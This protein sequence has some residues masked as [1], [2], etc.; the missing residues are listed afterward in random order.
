[1]TDD[2]K[3]IV[4]YQCGALIVDCTS[5]HRE[6]C[7]VPELI[8]IALGSDE[9]PGTFTVPDVFGG[10]YYRRGAQGLQPAEPGVPDVVICR[11]LDAFPGH[12]A[13]A[14]GWVAPCAWCQ[15]PIVYNPRG[16]HPDKPRIC[17]PC[18]RVTPLPLDS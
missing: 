7:P 17:M 18:A 10:G 13:P 2:R 4:C 3:P 16:P 11:P 1:M 12:R 9:R 14:G 8:A 5:P 6:G 15:Q